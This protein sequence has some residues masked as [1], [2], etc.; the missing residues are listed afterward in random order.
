MKRSNLL[1]YGAEILICQVWDSI[2]TYSTSGS[3]E[4]YEI[5]FLGPSNSNS[6]S[7]RNRLNPQSSNDQ[8]DRSNQNSRNRDGRIEITRNNYIIDDLRNSDANRPPRQHSQVSDYLIL[9]TLYTVKT[10]S[11]VMFLSWWQI[12]LV[13]PVFNIINQQLRLLLQHI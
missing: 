7:S 12:M 8:R 9:L 5:I 13:L 3:R 1:E 10:F 11:H 6:T 4:Q 2:K